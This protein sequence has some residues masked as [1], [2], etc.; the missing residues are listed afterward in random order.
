MQISRFVDAVPDTKFYFLQTFYP[1]IKFLKAWMC[2]KF[3][4]SFDLYEY[5]QKICAKT[6][7]KG[8]W[9]PRPCQKLGMLKSLLQ[10]NRI[11][12]KLNIK[13]QATT[14]FVRF[15][16]RKVLQNVIK[17]SWYQ[18][19]KNFSSAFL[20]NHILKCTYIIRSRIP[21][22]KSVLLINLLFAK[23]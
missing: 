2:F 11:C 16:R 14:N 3:W 22:N 6:R 15:K 10:K 21:F 8:K 18:K 13:H 17:S 23:I 7:K 4:A 1:S 9:L 19:M 12:L 5:F 20:E